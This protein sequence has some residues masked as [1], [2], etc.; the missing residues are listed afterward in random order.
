MKYIANF[1]KKLNKKVIKSTLCNVHA[2]T[3]IQ[4]RLLCF[5]LHSINIFSVPTKHNLTPVD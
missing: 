2:N 5:F 4:L 1:S 3:K